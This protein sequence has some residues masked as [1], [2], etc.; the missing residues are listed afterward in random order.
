MHGLSG[1]SRL[2]GRE[3]YPTPVPGIS[4]GKMD[5]QRAELCALFPPV[6]W[7]TLG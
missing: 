1:L 3:P 2:L 6:R 5:P 4:L 7:M